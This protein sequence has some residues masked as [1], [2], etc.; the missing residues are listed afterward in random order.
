MVEFLQPSL[1]RVDCP[2]K[3]ASIAHLSSK[4]NPV[5]PPRK[6]KPNDY[7]RVQKNHV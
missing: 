7:T 3:R 2:N 1:H 6:K 4:T 5:P